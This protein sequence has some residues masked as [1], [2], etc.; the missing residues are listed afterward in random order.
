MKKKSLGLNAL[1]NGLRSILNLIFPLITF[2]YVSHVLSVDGLG[3]YNFS[4]TYIG[5]FTLI[6]G[7]G[8]STYAIREGAKYRDDYIKISKF[9]SQI[10]TINI[11][12]TIIAYLLLFIS[13]LIFK[14]L[15]AYLNCILIFSITIFFTT[16]GTEWIYTIYE[17][18]AYITVRSIIF[19]IISIIL[20][21]LLVKNPGD[22]LW[23]SAITVFSTVGSNLFNFIHA[24]KLCSIKIVKKVNW[25]EHL[26]PILIIF[27]SAVAVN[28]YAFSDVTILGLIKG[29]YAV[30]IYSVATKIQTVSQGVLTAILT[31]TIPRL[32]MLFGQKRFI[33]YNQIL[34]KVFNTLVVLV[35]PVAIGI[36]ML[37]KEIVIIIAGSKYLPSVMALRIISWAIIFSIFG[38][39]I[40]DCVLLPAK[41]ENKLLI[42]TVVCSCFNIILNFIL[43]PIISYDGASLSTVLTE[44][45]SLIIDYYWGKDIMCKVTLNKNNQKVLLTT[46]IGCLFI[47]VYCILIQSLSLKIWLDICLSV[48]GSVVGYFIILFILKNPIIIEYLSDFKDRYLSNRN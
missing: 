8:I 19:K 42:G 18:Y 6:A 25:K 22:Y 14:N 34:T 46:V 39:L 7:L 5:Y 33:E 32:S 26:K 48:T 4:S 17:D 43:I 10:F 36:I 31:V 1:L 3:K 9:A 20:L 37:S 30:G 27:A 40:S 41:R 15:S 16:I 23:Y 24:K 45:L 13:L 38:W 28:I 35:L 29:D 21:F 44:L 47:V 2:P 12:S 11:V